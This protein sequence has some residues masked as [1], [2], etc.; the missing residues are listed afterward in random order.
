MYTTVVEGV[1]KQ[2]KVVDVHSPRPLFPKVDLGQDLVDYRLHVDDF[3]HLFSFDREVHAVVPLQH[4]ERRGLPEGGTE[5]LVLAHERDARKTC[6][7][8]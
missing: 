2:L 6:R 3:R 8:D 4:H 7:K 5:R 1:E